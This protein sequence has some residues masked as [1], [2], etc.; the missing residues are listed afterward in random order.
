[1]PPHQFNSFINPVSHPGVYDI[2]V[3]YPTGGS[4]G[5][6]LGGFRENQMEN[7]SFQPYVPRNQTPVDVNAVREV[8]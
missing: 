2:G 3:F 7:P 8:V 4:G 1:M 6:F 5:M